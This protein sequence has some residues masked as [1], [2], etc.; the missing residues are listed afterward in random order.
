MISYLITVF[1]QAAIY[2]L[3]SLGLNLQWGIGGLVNFG[4]VAF[5]T[6][7]AYA[8]A[9]LTRTGGLPWAVAVLVGVG[10]GILLA[11]LVGLTTLRLREDYLAIVTIGIAEIVRLITNNEEWLTQGTR[12][13]FGYQIP[14]LGFVSPEKYNFL[15]A[16][17][18]V[19]TIGFIVWQLEWLIRSPWGRVLKAIREDE[20]VA[21][22]LGKNV[23]V[24]KLQA[25]IFGGAIAAVAGAFLAWYLKA[26]Y[27]T[28]F[29]ALMTFEAWTIVAIG[30]AGNNL[31][32]L[33][34]ALFY[35]FYTT[36]PRF[37]PTAVKQALGG[38]RIE[39]IQVILIGL[40]LM[41]IMVWRPQGLLGK[42]AELSLRR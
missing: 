30:G 8:V 7:G 19:I 10:L 5:I 9:L 20:M 24:Y 26:I 28:T 14:F 23:F 11:L 12:G 21:T 2:A 41:A 17:G 1:V 3:F 42:K 16:L 15:F 6:I 18:L 27:P 29:T 33:V 32:V 13:V 37:L 34:G 38:G 39:A 40:T 4:H 25:F 35:Q 22:A 36:I 31:G